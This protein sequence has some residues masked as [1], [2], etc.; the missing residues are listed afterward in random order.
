MFHFAKKMRR[1]EKSC[2]ELRCEICNQ[3]FTTLVLLSNHYVDK[4]CVDQR[5]YRIYRMLNCC[6]F[7]FD[8]Q[9]PDFDK[10][11]VV[12]EHNSGLKAEPESLEHQEVHPKMIK[13]TQS[14][15]RRKLPS[16]C[17]DP[18]MSKIIKAER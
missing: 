14:S 11:E 18:R 5:Q 6:L 13:K 15:K 16:D 10:A 4:V 8:L 2:L 12:E 7:K 1:H 17:T 9:H 3:K